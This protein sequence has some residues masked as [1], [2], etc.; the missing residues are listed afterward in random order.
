MQTTQATGSLTDN[1]ELNTVELSCRKYNPLLQ[2]DQQLDKW[3]MYK[4]ST[5]DLREI[6]R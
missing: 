2:L 5:R 3:C 1:T 4:K 6:K